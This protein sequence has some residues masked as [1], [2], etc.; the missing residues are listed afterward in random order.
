[1][2]QSIWHFRSKNGY[3]IFHC[4]EYYLDLLHSVSIN[5]NETSANCSDTFAYF[6]I[7]NVTFGARLNPPE[8]ASSYHFLCYLVCICGETVDFN[9]P[10]VLE[11]D[12]P[13]FL[14]IYNLHFVA[15]INGN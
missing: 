14:S 6:S 13:K 3:A 4:Y 8:I 7:T 1:M 12:L 15:Q 5:C 10:F 9:P 2:S 11:T